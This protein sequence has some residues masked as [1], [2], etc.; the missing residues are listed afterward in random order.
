[1]GLRFCASKAQKTLPSLEESRETFRTRKVSRAAFFSFFSLQ[2]QRKEHPITKR[3]NRNDQSPKSKHK[4]TFPKHQK[5]R[6]KMS[7]P[8]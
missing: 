6:L 7:R 2:K 8:F 3:F 4:L 1:M 5:G